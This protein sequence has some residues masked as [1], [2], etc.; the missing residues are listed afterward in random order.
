MALVS[1]LKASCLLTER[2]VFPKV[3]GNRSPSSFPLSKEYTE[4]QLNYFRICYAFTDILPEGLREIFKQEWDKQHKLTKG[5]WKDEPRNGM[6]FYDGESSQ[7]KRRHAH[8]LATMQNGNRK[9]WDCT[10]LFYAILF[11]D[12]VGSSL[13]ATVWNNVDDLRRSRN[14][15]F[16]HFTS[17]SLSDRDF[18][19]AISKFDMAFQALGLP[20]AKIEDLKIQKMLATEELQIVLREVDDLKQEVRTQVQALEDELRKKSPS[21]CILPPKPSHDISGRER[22]VSEITQQLRKLKESAVNRPSCLYISGNPGSGKSQLAGLVAERFFDEVK[23]IPG[24][25]SFVMTLNAACPDSL[26]ESYVSLAHH[27]KCPDYSVMEILSSK[28]WE[29]E[30]KI[31]HLKMLIAVKVSCYTS[32][33]LVVDN[34]SNMSS[35][36]VHLPQTAIDTW[37]RGQMLITTQDMTS[38]PPVFSFVSHISVGKGMEPVDACSLLV[39]LSGIQDDVVTKVAEKLDYQPLAL[40]SAAVF[41]NE[42]RRAEESTHFGWKEYLKML[43][44]GKRETSEDT[45]AHTNLMYP[46]TMT[47]AI[48]LAVKTLMRSDELLKHIFTFLSLCAPEQLNVD[49]VISYIIKVLETCDEADK[50]QICSRLRRCSL[51]LF[52][53]NQGGYFIHVHQVVHYAIK[54]VINSTPEGQTPQVVNGVIT[55]FDTF[56][57]AV[58][59]V[60]RRLETMHI[61][62]HLKALTM[63]SDRRLVNEN[64]FPVHGKDLSDMYENLAEICEMHCE[65]YIAKVYLEYSL[66]LKIEKLGPEHVDVTWSYNKLANSYMALGDLV[67]AREYQQR[68]LSIQL[69]NFGSAPVSVATSYRNMAS[70]Y[71]NLGDL[72]QAMECQQRSLA[73]QLETLGPNHVS[74]AS[75]Y[76]TLASIYMATGDLKQSSEYQHRALAIQLKTLGPEHASVASSYNNLASVYLELGDLEQAKEFQERSLT[77]RLHKLGPEHVDVATS[78]NNLA[79]IFRALGD[80]QQAKEYQQRALAIQLEK[81]GPEHAS[82]TSSYNNLASIYLALGDLMQAKEY[83]ERALNIKIRKVGP[84]DVSVATSFNNLASIHLALGDLEQAKEYQQRA[85]AIQREKYGPEHVSVASSYS[86]LALVYLDLGD[87][88]LAKECQQRALAILLKKLGPEHVSVASSYSNLASI[89][90]ALGD[91]EQARE[92]QQFALGIEIKKV[93][94]KNISVAT[95]YNNLASISSALGDLEEAM[96]YQQRSL[97]IQ[98]EKLGAEH[99]SVA[100]SYSNLASIFMALGDL[101]Q[102]KEYQQLALDIQ[103]KKLGPKHASVASS[104]NNLASIYLNLGDL[105]QAKEYQEQALSIR[106]HKL[107]P[108]HVSVATSYSNLASIFMALGDNPKAKEYQQRALAIQLAKLGPEHASVASSFDNLA[109]INKA[110]GD[111]KGA[112]EYQRHALA[113]LLKKV[114]RKVKK[115]VQ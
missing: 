102:A 44:D 70:I 9:E 20:T 13:S 63:L 90:K 19:N 82:V 114:G 16:A 43:K 45:L 18:R 8:L 68:A 40:A 42:I 76:S 41:L 103:L 111:L 75:S 78:Y 3:P 92:Y 37:A 5:E 97:A 91:L 33:L 47:E 1:A 36:D 62:P 11:S 64:L 49:I 73:I 110:L 87:L 65:F 100:S 69:K 84:E 85:L 93:G 6:D 94:W 51:L 27:L 99:V 26:L 17:G 109:S 95:S 59:P 81:L 34:V 57:D 71:L 77:I 72:G 2:I 56:I 104:Y 38:V 58:P 39:K 98:L 21:F 46:T 101:E 14:Q 86:N 48:N 105:M 30:E 28:D 113:I 106:L 67:E 25:S 80:L 96:E 7:N 31:T 79:S 108:E 35:V 74:V 53:D 24:S 54:N 10:M 52:E 22:D 60:N 29:V 115:F 32:W 12:C 23:N 107:G 15:E 4:E 66:S 61:V 88:Q 50:E 89:F 112:N 55:S 83:Q